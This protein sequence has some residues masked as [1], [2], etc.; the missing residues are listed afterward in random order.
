M[1]LYI[2]GIYIIM[3]P[4]KEAWNGA[5]VRACELL[6]ARSHPALHTACRVPIHHRGRRWGA[7]P[8]AYGPDFRGGEEGP[9]SEGRRGSWELS[10]LCGPTRWRRPAPAQALFLLTKHTSRDKTLNSIRQRH[11][12]LYPELG[13]S[14]W[15]PAPPHWVH[16]GR[17]ARI[18]ARGCR[19]F[20]VGVGLQGSRYVGRERVGQSLA[21]A[22][23]HDWACIWKGSR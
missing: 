10:A 9:G 8:L 12:V 1:D 21:E 3:I 11:R 14:E 5:G 19:A 17:S 7:Y 15:G 2:L 13:S 22:G 4:W 16:R 6:G 20:R 23:W 18:P